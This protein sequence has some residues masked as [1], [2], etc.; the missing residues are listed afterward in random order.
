MVASMDAKKCY[1]CGP[2]SDQPF[3][4][5]KVNISNVPA[6]CDEFDRLMPDKKSQYEFQ[7]PENHIGC[8]LRV[9][10]NKIKKNVY[11]LI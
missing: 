5:N 2:Y 8:L 4:D 9:G 11:K 3:I 7:C 1:I 6:S 10:G